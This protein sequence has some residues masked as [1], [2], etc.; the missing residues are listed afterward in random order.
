M[1]AMTCM[2]HECS[3]ARERP[4]RVACALDEM[5]RTQDSKSAQ[6]ALQVLVC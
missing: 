3:D 4:R 6:R 5:D 2:E 1:S